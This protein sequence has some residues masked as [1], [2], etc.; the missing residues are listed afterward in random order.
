MLVPVAIWTSA[1]LRC[2][3]D[4]KHVTVSP[5]ASHRPYL[6]LPTPASSGGGRAGGCRSARGEGRDPTELS[7]DASGCIRLRGQTRTRVIYL[8]LEQL[9]GSCAR[10][11]VTAGACGHVF[12]PLSESLPIPAASLS[13][14]LIRSSS[15]AIYESPWYLTM[16]ILSSCWLSL[17]SCLSWLMLWIRKR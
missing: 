7:R 3:Y 9:G 13:G 16:A 8:F 11:E 14:C 17:S 10:A 1:L 4:E 15:A 2:S 6:A 12:Y 5:T